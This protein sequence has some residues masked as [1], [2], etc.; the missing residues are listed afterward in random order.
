M[1]R[2]S[3]P[4]IALL[5]LVLTA[6]LFGGAVGCGSTAIG[7]ADG[8]GTAGSTPGG[9]VGGKTVTY[10]PVGSR[11]S[12]YQPLPAVTVTLTESNGKAQTAVSDVDGNFA[13]GTTTTGKGTLQFSTSTGRNAVAIN[14]E[15][16]YTHVIASV[17]PYSSV[18]APSGSLTI[19]S[20]ATTIKPGGS[21]WAYATLG[22][23]MGSEVVWVM[24]T[25]TDAQLVP[26][27][28]ATAP[29]VT[30]GAKTGTLTVQA[31]TKNLA[32]NA[33]TIKIAK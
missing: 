9:R 11:A 10:S 5:G 8:R 28:L 7:D 6:L 15:T 1:T 12:G 24:K 33:L 14:I 31:L 25:K 27:F 22:S 20:T 16:G 21:A 17:V 26:T 18:F 13:F 4:Q 3:G 2:K 23:A 30:A 32:S 19:R 29:V